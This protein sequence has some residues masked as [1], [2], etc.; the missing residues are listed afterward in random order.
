MLKDVLLFCSQVWLQI[1]EAQN[2]NMSGVVGVAL[3]LGWDY[4]W[5]KLYTWEREIGAW[6]LP[7]GSF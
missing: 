2:S 1:Q 7:V 6:G 3:S 5:M 4:S